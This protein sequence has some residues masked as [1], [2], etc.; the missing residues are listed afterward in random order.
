MVN[1]LNDYSGT[2][3]KCTRERDRKVIRIPPD[4]LEVPQPSKP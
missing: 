1:L 4:G 2:W 3:V